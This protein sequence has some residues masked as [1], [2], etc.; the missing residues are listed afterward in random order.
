MSLRS[1][2]TFNGTSTER[3]LACFARAFMASLVFVLLSAT[4]SAA[5]VPGSLGK[6]IPAKDEIGDGATVSQYRLRVQTLSSD[7]DPLDAAVL[8]SRLSAVVPEQTFRT[9]GLREVSLYSRTSTAVVLI[10]TNDGI[11][12]G[13]LISKNGLILTNWH[14]VGSAKEVGVVFKP[15]QQSRKLT[16]ADV[17]RAKVLRVDQIADLALVRVSRPPKGVSPLVLGTMANAQVGADV[18]AIGHPTGQTW[19]YTKG[20]ISQIRKSY[21]WST[22]S[23]LKH[24]A[25]VIQTQTPI[26]PG[27]SGGPLMD[28]NG[29][30]VGVNS[31]K[32]KGEALNF[33]VDVEEVKKF[34]KRKSNRYARNLKKAARPRQR[35]TKCKV[36]PLWKGRSPKKDADVTRYD[37]N[38]DGLADASLKVPDDSSKPITLSVD[39]KRNGKIDKIY[40]DR[41]R[42]HK[43]D[44]SF[45]DVDGDGKPDLVGYHP[46]GKIKPSRFE[47]YAASR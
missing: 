27:N 16:K 44:I 13:S 17:R 28:E 43:W 1:R 24:R 29:G 32:A 34:L 9:R 2:S 10:I 22:E 20:T 5:E 35:P 37:S 11:G 31:F 46:D 18:H 33:A 42:D 30:V 8:H 45:Y 39:S 47:K 19:T 6:S 15:T 25:N 21:R 36:K 38:C 40:V 26:N 12:S 41:N 7:I 14:V 3:V 4:V 23:K